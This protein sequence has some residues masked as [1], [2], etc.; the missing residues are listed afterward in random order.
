MKYVKITRP[1]FIGGNPVEPGMVVPVEDKDLSNVVP[2]RGM[3]V[4]PPASVEDVQGDAG[5]KPESR[6]DDLETKVTK[7]KTAPR[8]KKTK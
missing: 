1:C 8:R 6:E 2:G 4:D 3:I 5:P 7:R